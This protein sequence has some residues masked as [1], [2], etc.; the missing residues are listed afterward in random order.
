MSKIK[1]VLRLKYLNQLSNRQIQTMTGVSR[2]SVANYIKSYIELDSSLEEVLSLSDAD[3]S[4]LFFA[5]KPL[6]TKTKPDIIH[7]DWNEVH[8]ELSK[9]GMTRLLLWEE[10]KEKQPSLYSYS[11]FNRYYKKF[12]KT[13]NPSMRQ[14]HYSG[15]K[16]FIDYK[17]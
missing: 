13:V 17:P 5:K 6:T 14:V 4:Q 2:N 15:D 7:P 3:L 10:Y 11:Q 1:E 8:E 9:K 16:L 12:I